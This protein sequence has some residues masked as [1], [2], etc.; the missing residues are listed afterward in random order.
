M[1]AG[2]AERDAEPPTVWEMQRQVQVQ[3]LSSALPLNSPEAA[4]RPLLVVN[5]KAVVHEGK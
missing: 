2:L 1:R 5:M 4:S 3:V